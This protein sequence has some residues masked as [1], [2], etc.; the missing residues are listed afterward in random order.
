VKD[1]H[2]LGV[3]KAEGRRG[4]ADAKDSNVIAVDS[5]RGPGAG[6][7]FGLARARARGIR[8]TPRLSPRIELLCV[9]RNVL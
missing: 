5:I 2:S 9:V 8:G 4:G 3:R 1:S 7:V 6:M